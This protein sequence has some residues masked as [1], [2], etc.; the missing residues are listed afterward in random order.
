MDLGSEPELEEGPGPAAG[1]EQELEDEG[2]GLATVQRKAREL[3]A[4]QGKG[5]DVARDKVLHKKSLH[6]TFV[7]HLVPKHTEAKHETNL[8]SQHLVITVIATHGG[9]IPR[10]HVGIGVQLVGP[11]TTRVSAVLLLGAVQG[12][13]ATDICHGLL[14]LQRPKLETFLG[15]IT[16][17]EC[18]HTLQ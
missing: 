12:N 11:S 17:L 5:K 1:S 16:R 6:I 14:N 3:A 4:D 10:S 7:S 2:P 18:K 13:L 8:Q 9:S 15:I